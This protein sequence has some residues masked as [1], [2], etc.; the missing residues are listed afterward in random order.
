MFGQPPG[1][2]AFEIG[3]QDIGA[4]QCGCGVMRDGPAVVKQ[5]RVFIMVVVRKVGVQ[6]SP[7]Y[8]LMGPPGM[9]VEIA[10][11]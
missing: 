5:R 2:G 7:S 8:R 9:M 4:G 6:S 3:M 11:L 1:L 10:C